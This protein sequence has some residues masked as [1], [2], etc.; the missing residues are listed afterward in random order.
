M[1]SNCEQKCSELTAQQQIS[2]FPESTSSTKQ[3]SEV[4]QL[5]NFE[6]AQ[7]R[8]QLRQNGLPMKNA[9]LEVKVVPDQPF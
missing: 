4:F 5:R 3:A 2:C 7:L 8:E 1:Q 6:M 9:C